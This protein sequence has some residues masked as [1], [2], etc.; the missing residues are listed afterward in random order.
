MKGRSTT[1]NVFCSPSTLTN[2]SME[3]TL[4]AARKFISFVNSSPSPFHAVDEIKQRLIKSGFTELRESVH[5]DI[6]QNSKYFVTKNESTIIAFAVGG[7]F[8]PGNPFSIVGAHTDSPC[9]RVKPKSATMK[10][11]F[12]MVGVETYGGG[13]WHTWFDRDLTVAG[14]VLIKNGG[15]IDHRLVHV[16][17]PILRIPNIAIH[18]QR[19]MNEKFSPNKE[20]H[21]CPVLAT[22]VQAEL[23]GEKKPVPDSEA[24]TKTSDEEMK[25]QADKHHPALIKI[26]CEELKI[27]PEQILDFELCLADT[28]PAVI[29]GILDEFIFSPRLDNLLNAYAACEA[30]IE[31]CGNNSL[32]TETNIRMISLFDNEES[33][34]LQVYRLAKISVDFNGLKQESAT[35]KK[36]LMPQSLYYIDDDFDLFCSREK[37]ESNHQPAF[38]KGIVIKFNSNQ[39]YATTAVTATILREIARKVDAPLQEVV[40]RNDSACGSTIGPIMSAK[41][42]MKTIDVGG[43]QLSMHS[44]REMCCTSSVHQALTLFKAFFELYPEVSASINF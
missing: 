33:D 23:Q 24:K 9:L 4:T 40:V 7:K 28:Q 11:G 32:A 29:G 17:R 20:T 43:P 3:V 5:W 2:P 18:L 10:S 16:K 13:T 39:R 1:S 21:L 38:H 8:V 14:R 12:C 25:T 31:S 30:L 37:H 6:K 19:D 36:V 35:L 15:K 34:V 41:L 44:I 22:A 42:G 26:L 27:N